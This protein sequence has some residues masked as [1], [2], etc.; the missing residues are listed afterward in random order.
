MESYS[1]E[2]INLYNKLAECTVRMKNGDELAFNDIYN[3]MFPH[4]NALI[5]SRKV[6]DAD[7]ADIAQ[8]IMISVYKYVTTI[9]D[10]Q[11][12]YKWIMRLSSNKIVD[13]FRKNSSKFE[14]ETHIISE[15][16]DMGEAE[17][18]YNKSHSSE[19]ISLKIPEDIFVNK[20]RQQKLFEIVNTLKE[21]QRQIIVLHCINDL[22]FKE[23]AETL[24]VSENTVKTKFYRSL[25][26]LETSI[27]AVEEREGIRLHSVGIVPFILFM[28]MLYAQ[29]TTVSA[30]VISEV[31]ERLSKQINDLH[32]APVQNTNVPGKKTGGLKALIGSH[33]VASTIIA[34]VAVG[35]VAGGIYA[36][37]QINS[38]EPEPIVED[39]II[40]DIVN[41]EPVVVE[42]EDTESEVSETEELSDSEVFDNYLSTISFLSGDMGEIEC[43]KD[44]YNLVYTTDTTINGS[45]GSFVTDLDNDGSEELLTVEYSSDNGIS[46]NVFENTDGNCNRIDGVSFSDD[47][48]MYNQKNTDV[49]LYEKDGVKYILF[50]Y[51]NE[52][53]YIADGYY[54]GFALCHYDGMSLITDCSNSFAGSS[55]EDEEYIDD[56]DNMCSLLG[57]SN[58]DSYTV[59][60]YA[61]FSDY[62]PEAQHIASVIIT[63]TVSF[64]E[65]MPY[66]QQLYSD[67]L[68]SFKIATISIN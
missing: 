36:I 19:S 1:Q 55:I 52:Y 23:I 61:K 24:G 44:N 30:Q 34:L 66:M 42:S 46:I 17:Q 6:D 32:N 37:S 62:M 12:T 3:L 59:E 18:L 2:Q 43:S 28:F 9:N 50:Q 15:E 63:P 31:S 47:G 26:K 33:K 56:V 4:I 16:D 25:N 14:N 8:E 57:L 38:S 45:I 64:E 11:S 22:T 65:F 20:E 29:R 10:P 41:T 35:A 60:N 51:Y 13:Y 39:N 49:Y 53:S 5:K 21:E 67:E 68:A 7:V 48:L 40:N 58:Y 54:R 27:Y